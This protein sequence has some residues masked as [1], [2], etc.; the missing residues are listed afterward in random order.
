MSNILD[1]VDAAQLRND[2]PAFRPGDTLD[3]N[4]KVIEGNNERTQ[5]F[6]GVCIRRQGSGI[7]ET[8][9]VR[10]VSFGIGVERTFPV[11]SPN[12]ASIEVVRHGR[13][14]RAKLYF[15]RDLRGKKARLKERR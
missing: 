14:R 15:L 5:L 11:H 8:F 6:K 10:K 3:V 2:I 1:K 7:R 13:V 12:I 9:T 4:V